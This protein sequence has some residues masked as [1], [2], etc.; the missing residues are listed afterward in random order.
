MRRLTKLALAVSVPLIAWFV[1]VVRGRVHFPADTIPEG[2]Y[3]RIVLAVNDGRPRDAFAYL[4]TQAQWACFTI[5]DY[6]SKA[7]ARIAQGY[8]EPQKSAALAEYR[9]ET[10][11]DGADVW[12]AVAERRGF[13]AVLR[14]DLSGASKVEIEGERA[15][16]ETAHGTRYA[17]RRRENG[18]WGLTT[19]TGELLA[20]ADKAAR[21]LQMVDRA[22]GDYERAAR[23]LPTHPALP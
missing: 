11:L 22:A 14:K 6:R 7:A 1:L 9:G 8:P 13:L 17:F 19:F 3:A 12:V 4:E 21:D 15:T 2:A 23:E 20:E 5:G 18:I 16:I 10:A